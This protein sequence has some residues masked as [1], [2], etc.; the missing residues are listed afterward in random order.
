MS[1]GSVNEKGD[2]SSTQTVKS[3][4]YILIPILEGKTKND[5]EGIDN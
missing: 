4:L 5:K 2:W 3:T 1:L